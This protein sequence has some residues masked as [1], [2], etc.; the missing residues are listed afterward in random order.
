MAKAIFDIKSVQTEATKSAQRVFNAG[1]GV[2]DLAVERIRDYAA[3][4]QKR[5]TAAQHSVSTFDP[6]S[7]RA[8]FEKRVADLQA[9]AVAV[10]ARLQDTLGLGVTT[11][12]AAY[13]DL[14]K[15]GQTLVGR[16]RRQASTQ[17]AV[18][19]AESTVARAKATK[20]TAKKA[21]ASTRRSA[22]ATR[23]TAKK[24]VSAGSRALSDGAKKVG[25]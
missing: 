25:D 14:V 11:A 21:A 20:T 1:V 17:E 19:A 23:T 12:S 13:D 16:I 8:A 18:A 4:A 6:K 5:L 15:R 10:P 3:G 7:G 22:K 2:T 9:G 24:T